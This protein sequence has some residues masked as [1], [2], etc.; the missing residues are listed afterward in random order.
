MVQSVVRGQI[1]F[2]QSGSWLHIPSVRSET[3]F[4]F[5]CSPL[6]LCHIQS[7]RSEMSFLFVC[8]PIVLCLRVALRHMESRAAWWGEVAEAAPPNILRY[9]LKPAF[10]FDCFQPGAEWYLMLWIL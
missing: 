8:S 10:G 6:V 5:V 7:V 1:L 4:L 2:D 3:S 9:V